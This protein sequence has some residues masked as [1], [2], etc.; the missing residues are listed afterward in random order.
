MVKKWT[1]LLFEKYTYFSFLQ[2]KT[3]KSIYYIYQGIG[4]KNNQKY[5][6]YS[7]VN[8]KFSF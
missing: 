4:I 3:V 8:K 5:L 7:S 1:G 6:G 2:V